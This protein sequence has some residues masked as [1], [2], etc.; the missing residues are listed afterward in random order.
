M[1]GDAVREHAAHA[2]GLVT[3][4]GRHFSVS[5]RYRGRCG[6]F[7]VELRVDVDGH[8]PLKRVSADYYGAQTG[9]FLGSM[10]VDAVRVVPTAG[11]TTI[12]GRGVFSWPTTHRIVRVTI[13]R[14]S[15][16][17]RPQATLEHLSPDGSRGHAYVCNFESTS[18]RR[19]ALT[20]ACQ[21]GVERFTTYDTGDLPAPP[22]K[23]ELSHQAAFAEA[24]IELVSSGPPTIVATA[25]AGADARW[26][27]AELHAAMEQDFSRLRDRPEW[28]IWLLHAARHD[29]PRLQGLM[30]D[31][32][33]LHRQG[34]AVFHDSIVGNGPDRARRQLHTCVHELGHGFNLLHSWQRSRATPPVASRPSATSWMNYPQRFAGGEQSFWSR[35]AFQFDDFEL[36]HLR[37][38]F[39]EDVIMGGRPFAGDA[40]ADAGAAEHGPRYNRGL[41]LR[42]S[43]LREFALGLPVTVAIELRATTAYNQQVPPIVGP[44]VGN[45]DIFI[46]RP[47]GSEAA[48][49]PLLQHC[50]GHDT[51]GLSARDR[52]ICDHAFIHY[53]K[54][55]FAFRAPGV[56]RVRARFV[57]LHG[58]TVLS[59]TLTIR[60]VPPATRDDRQIHTMID[61]NHGVGT[62]MSLMGSDAPALKAA[63]DTLQEIIGSFPDHP[64]ASVARLAR[65]RNAARGFKL[66]RRNGEV[67]LRPPNIE[68]AHA[69]VEPI[70]DLPQVRRATRTGIDPTTQDRAVADLVREIGVRPAVPPVVRNF[71]RSRRM[72]IATVINRLPPG[73]VALRRS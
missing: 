72:E 5:G 49:E 24:G 31:R 45:V 32:R 9:E 46:R 29:D 54:D 20:E 21:E 40:R 38:A 17:G 6:D 56:Y 30:F 10:R 39:Q 61:G 33:G 14:L 28:A 4:R 69:L 44:R 35:F 67:R 43:A 41:T 70:L 11:E 2:Q 68:D 18:F 47:D 23:R 65:A 64:V 25:D 58:A 12:T 7:E 16:E 8:R 73:D 13:P 22:P 63:N 1:K 62:L 3:P 26:S 57:D 53:G 34:C 48:F 52:P 60:V 37:H 71:I 51:V 66:I 27:D 36:A 59:N 55:G 42:L 50:R 19:V 15:R